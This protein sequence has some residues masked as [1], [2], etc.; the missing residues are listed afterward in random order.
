MLRRPYNEFREANGLDPVNFEDLAAEHKTCEVCLCVNCLLVAFRTTKESSPEF[1]LYGGG[2]LKNIGINSH[3]GPKY[4]D[5]E[6]KI[7]Q[8]K[9]FG[10]ETAHH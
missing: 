6:L 8:K 10:L 2:L 7:P 4:V 1:T 3:A 9:K 5:E